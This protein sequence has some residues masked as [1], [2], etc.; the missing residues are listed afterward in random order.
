[1]IV[2]ESFLPAVNGVTNSVVRV[3]AHLRERGHEVLIVAPGPGADRHDDVPVMRVPSIPFPLYPEMS[4]VR[5]TRRVSDAIANFRPDV[6]HVASPVVLGSMGLI[7]AKRHGVPAVA[8]FQTDLAGFASDYG[9]GVASNSIWKVLRRI[10]RLSDLTLAPS[11]PVVKQLESHG[12]GAVTKWGR[13][14][15]LERFNPRHRDEAWRSEVAPNGEMIVGYVGRL[16]HE[17][18]VSDLSVLND[19]TG[20]KV[21]V[22]GDGPAA[23]D[24]RRALPDAVFLGALGGIDLSRAYA[25]LDVFVHT[26]PHETFCQT[27]QEAKASRVPVIAPRSGGPIDLV[28]PG[29]GYLYRPDMPSHIRSYVDYLRLLPHFR[30]FLAKNAFDSVQDRSWA[31]V[32]DELIGHYDATIR[33]R[34]AGRDLGGGVGH[35]KDRPTLDGSGH[36]PRKMAVVGR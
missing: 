7:A 2:T 9:F 36:R 11:T 28:T 14:V 8:V 32:G 24:V 4:M 19:S 17:K 31:Q 30:E 13:G 22:V 15:D 12:F 5:P 29:T 16:A 3:A 10:H 27:I 33:A 26:G 25:S 20:V 34:E 1:M 21:V 18:R 35:A 6:M 23:N